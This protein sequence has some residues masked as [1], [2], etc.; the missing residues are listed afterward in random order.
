MKDQMASFVRDQDQKVVPRLLGKT[1]EKLLDPVVVI[2]PTL[3]INSTT[4][5]IANERLR[6]PEAIVHRYI[7]LPYIDEPILENERL[8]E[9]IVVRTNSIVAHYLYE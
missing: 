5:N 8:R 3:V 1:K 9:V 2:D 4:C 7:A 6:L